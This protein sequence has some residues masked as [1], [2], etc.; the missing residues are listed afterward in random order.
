M[1][2][3]APTCC[4][5]AASDHVAAAPP[6]AALERKRPDALVIASDA[7]YLTRASELV[8]FAAKLA[9]PTMYPFREFSQPGG[10][11]S[12]GT[13]S[14]TTDW[15]ASMR[16]GFSRAQSQPIYRSCSR[17]CSSW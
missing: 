12:Y 3:V 10:L 4:P 6:F 1:R 11:V 13:G 5:R 14:T 7:F 2:R 9:L 16:A 15:P 17:P 8:S